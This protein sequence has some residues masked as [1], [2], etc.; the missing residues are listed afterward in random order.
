MLNPISAPTIYPSEPLTGMLQHM[1]ASDLFSNS[2]LQPLITVLSELRN[3][4]K[5]S[6]AILYGSFAKGIHHHRSDI[7]LAIAIP[8][9]TQDIE[10]DIIDQILMASERPISILRLDDLEESPLVIQESLKG[11]HLVEPDLKVFYEVADWALH[12]SE[13]IRGRRQRYA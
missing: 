7:D 11:V 6:I 13:S 12:E 1:N 10:M 2:E 5:L 4:E 8:L 9:A 3:A